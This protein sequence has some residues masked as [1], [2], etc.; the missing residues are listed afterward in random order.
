MTL[1]VILLILILIA[2][3]FGG[4]VVAG[5]F[6]FILKAGF[7][8]II[9]LLVLFILLKHWLKMVLKSLVQPGLLMALIL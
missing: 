7:F 3:V 2:L 8:I 5:I 6:Q 1:I 4:D 9:A